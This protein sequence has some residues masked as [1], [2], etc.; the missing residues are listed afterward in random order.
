MRL[1]IFGATGRAGRA[2]V[3]RAL[4]QG[5]EVAALTHDPAKIP[6]RQRLRVVSGDACDPVS[7]GETINGAQAIVSTLGGQDICTEG[8]RPILST[9]DISGPVASLS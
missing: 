1:A 7:V 3:E 6:P 4:R 8:I 2:V 5:H 9:L